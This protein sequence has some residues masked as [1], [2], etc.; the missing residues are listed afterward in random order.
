MK[1]KI[2]PWTLSVFAILVAVL[3]VVLS[4]FKI[5]H[6][7]EVLGADLDSEEREVVVVEGVM[8]NDSMVIVAEE[9]ASERV[10]YYLAYPGILPDHPFY[11]LK[12][13]RDRV[14]GWLIRD[15]TKKTEWLL[16]MADKRIGAAKALVEG[17]KTQLGVSTASKAE[18]YLE[19]AVITLKETEIKGK[20]MAD[21][22]AKIS[23]AVAKHEE[24]LKEI[25]DQLTGNEK[26][27][28]MVLLTYPE[29]FLREVKD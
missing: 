19:R 4:A 26:E 23:L 11:W 9:L 7:L 13:M 28:M 14:W 21:L 29:R 24:V 5:S 12:M 3:M 10:D 22:K 27:T 25:I 17:S 15:H 18:K 16:L 1:K 20:N 2:L 8:E 6:P